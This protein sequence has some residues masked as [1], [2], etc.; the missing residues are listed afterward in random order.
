M[1]TGAAAHSFVVIVTGSRDWVSSEAIWRTLDSTHL[2]CIERGEE[3]VLR[4]GDCD[5][6]VDK[7]ALAW[8]IE[9]GVTFHRY[10][11]DWNRFGFGAGPRRNAEM[12]NDGGDLCTAFWRV[13]SR[14]HGKG[15]FDC[16]R[17][18]SSKGIRVELYSSTYFERKL[19]RASQKESPQ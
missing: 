4:I 15:T 18:V 14:S 13:D 5:S 16:V 9:R 2:G 7:F 10:L 19:S 12:A 11:A 17:K 8:A 6:G 1:Q 3:L